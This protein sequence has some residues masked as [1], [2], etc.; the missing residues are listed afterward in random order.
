MARSVEGEPT[1]PNLVG[2]DAQNLFL[3]E[4]PDIQD[5]GDTSTLT[6]ESVGDA[7][8]PVLRLRGGGGY[9]SEDE[10]LYN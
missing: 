7:T 2:E 9:A 5:G 4:S 3:R 10:S 8:K 6:C 1:E